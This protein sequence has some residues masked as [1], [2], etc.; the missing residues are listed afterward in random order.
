MWGDAGGEISNYDASCIPSIN[1]S[2]IQGGTNSG[3]GNINAD[4]L[5]INQVDSSTAPFTGGNY[6][7]QTG[8]P[9]IDAGSNSL[10]TGNINSD[11]DL[12]GNQRL[13]GDSID[14]GAYEFSVGPVS[15]RLLQFSGTPK[16]GSNYLI[17]KTS[18]EINS[19]QFIVERSTDDQ[20]FTEI[21]TVKAQ[22]F[23]NGSYNYTDNISTP[24][25]YYYR[26]KME[27]NN[28]AFTYSN[29]ILLN[30][31]EAGLISVYPNPAVNRFTIN[32]PQTMVNSNVSI[33]DAKGA[34]VLKAVITNLQ[35]N[36]DISTWSSGI[37]FVHFADGTTKML[38]KE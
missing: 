4:P 29:I 9:C 15:L 22:G 26:L 31:T 33:T 2:D 13:Y 14:M 16:D 1:F 23:G 10:Y 28:G 5:F 36:V 30:S 12:A 20:N 6:Q 19:K 38:M 21:G 11:L 18:N 27:D 8:S 3:I 24:G 25:S 35:Q 37:Y 34:T 7:L 32:V 17:W